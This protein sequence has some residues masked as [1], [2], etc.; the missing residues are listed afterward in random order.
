M[1]T[2]STITRRD[3]I[4]VASTAGAGL[5]L[6]FTLPGSKRWESPPPETGEAFA[7]N[8]W[9]SI[10]QAGAVTIKV[11]KSEMGQGVYTALPMIVAEELD[12]DWSAVRVEQALADK[13]FGGM[14][15]GGSTSVRTS[16]D[17][18]R[19]AGATARAMLVSAAAETWQVEPKTCTTEK[20]IVTH[21]PTGRTLSYGKLAASA[22]AQPVP[23]N[24]SAE[25]PV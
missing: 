15:T 13:K 7:P 14:G 4:K 23:E 2:T 5:V 10:D 22:S 19:K 8:A 11:G 17:M 16:W 20:G 21:T 3:F 24:R 25:E 6:G 18:L 9:L 12:A 1:M